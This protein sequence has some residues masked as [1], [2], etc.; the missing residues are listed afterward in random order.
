MTINFQEDFICFLESPSSEENIKKLEVWFPHYLKEDLKNRAEVYRG[1]IRGAHE[2]TLKKIFRPFL[3]LLGE[4][5]SQQLFER[6]A[7]Q[8]FSDHFDLNQY[9]KNFGQFIQSS[10]PWVKEYPYVP[11]F[12]D[13]CWCWQQAFLKQDIPPLLSLSSLELKE[14]LKNAKKLRFQTSEELILFESGF[15]V[16][17][18]WQYC[19]PE[20]SGQERKAL[21]LSSRVKNYYVLSRYEGKVHVVLVSRS[22]FD[23]LKNIQNKELEGNLSDFLSDFM[24]LI[25]LGWVKMKTTT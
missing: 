15:P 13:F 4:A 18:I 19:Q 14:M 9:G 25:E 21:D 22:T 2:R 8:Y 3:A 10:V 12:A 6:Y 5:V 16:Y 23:L 11:D 20:F 7:E 17:E 24:E 1:S